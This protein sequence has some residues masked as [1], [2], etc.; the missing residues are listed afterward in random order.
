MLYDFKSSCNS[1]KKNKY[2]SEYFSDTVCPCCRAVGRFHIHAS[3]S[4][5]LI[6]LNKC[7]VVEVQK[8]ILRIKCVS[9]DSTHAVLPFDIIPYKIVSVEYFLKVLIMLCGNNLKIKELMVLMNISFQSIYGYNHQFKSFFV[10]L[11]NFLRVC[12]M[13]TAT[14]SIKETLTYI[15]PSNNY[16]NFLKKYLEYNGRPFLMSKFKNNLSPPVYFGIV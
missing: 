8:K 1:Y 5:N 6:Y 11:N 10:L 9:C 2:M 14:S 16:K 7:D 15:Y 12:Y 4:R 3:Y 13:T